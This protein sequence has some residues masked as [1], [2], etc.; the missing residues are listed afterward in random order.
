M[1]IHRVL[2][3]QPVGLWV[4]LADGDEC[5]PFSCQ[6][7]AFLTKNI[8]N[9]QCIQAGID[10]IKREYIG[11]VGFLHRGVDVLAHSPTVYPKPQMQMLQGFEAV[12]HNIHKSYYYCW[13][14]YIY[15]Y[16]ILFR[17]DM[18]TAEKPA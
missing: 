9:M 17:A 1:L 11:E 18:H 5:I 12:F 7:P 13:L 8:H 10:R 3:P 16:Y 2:Y 4:S 14:I 6:R 15:S